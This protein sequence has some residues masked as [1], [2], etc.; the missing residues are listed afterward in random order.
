MQ[1]LN[2]GETQRL[3]FTATENM[4]SGNYLY[5]LI[6]HISTN[7]SFFL[8]FPKSANVS[9]YTDRWDGFDVSIPNIPIG[10]C[11]YSLYEGE[12]GATSVD[13]PEITRMIECGLYQILTNE[14]TDFTIENPITYFEPSV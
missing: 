14:S 9:T 2:S 13:S 3:F 7:E 6:E 8:S 1:L 4:V 11:R 10:Q 5:L 12:T